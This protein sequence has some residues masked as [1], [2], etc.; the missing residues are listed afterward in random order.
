MPAV[1][2]HFKQNIF[3][4]SRY[5]NENDFWLLFHFCELS[6]DPNDESL[7]R[8][9]FLVNIK[10]NNFCSV[11]HWNTERVISI[12]IRE[13]KTILYTLG[14]IFNYEGYPIKYPSER[15]NCIEKKEIIL[16]NS[17]NY[18]EDR[19]LEFFSNSNFPMKGIE[20]DVMSEKAHYYYFNRFNN[21]EVY[22][23]ITLINKYFYYSSISA[24]HSIIY[25]RMEEGIKGLKNIDGKKTVIYDGN[26]INAIDVKSI[27]R[28]YFTLGYEKGID[29]L[30]KSVNDFYEKLL[31]KKKLNAP[32]VSDIKYRLPFNFPLKVVVLGQY[33]HGKRFIAYDI[34]EVKPNNKEIV[35]FFSVDEFDLFNINDKRS[36]DARET[37]ERKDGTRLGGQYVGDDSSDLDDS[38]P[39]ISSLPKEEI[40]IP[41]KNF[42]F[43]TPKST[44]LEKIDQKH[45]YICDNL[46]K[47]DY[48]GYGINEG[49]TDPNSKT[50]KVNGS[51][52][53][54]ISHFQIFLD[55]L[56]CI[57]EDNDFFVT[58]ITI[59]GSYKYPY[60]IA[61][62]YYKDNKPYKVVDQ[63]L[64]A[65]I[66]YNQR[67]FCI[68]DTG[69][70]LRIGIFEN[71]NIPFSESDD[72]TLTRFINYM[73]QNYHFLWSSVF[74]DE[75]I[76][77]PNK[78][79]KQKY[80][81]ILENFRFR[82]MQ[83]FEHISPKDD[84]NLAI[85]LAGRIKRRIKESVK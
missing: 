16:S 27:A 84:E 45:K 74:Y 34:V 78:S 32:L 60:S 23:P 19:L 1:P 24:I 72:D 63:M 58:L 48:D 6:Y 57:N 43:D 80:D 38:K 18:R 3:E 13:E 9:I 17:Q 69:P 75:K 79:K 59:N 2:S 76:S 36:S 53:E 73:L 22:V 14:T 28:Y 54:G 49:Q 41:K 35:K 15:E 7:K 20:Q 21:D 29:I 42:F 44:I 12:K 47:K 11:S 81:R 68:I 61:P 37:K 55:A 5:S 8:T 70:G 65:N 25:D 77:V 31:N 50:R 66:V 85:N 83:P 56:T 67:H 33:I 82:I 30:R 10:D 46:V 62:Y 52:L 51:I 71:Y 64:I 4:V 40:S 26:Y 39:T